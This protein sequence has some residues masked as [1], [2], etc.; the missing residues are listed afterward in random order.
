MHRAFQ[1]TVLIVVA[2]TA[3]IIY[4]SIF[5]TTAAHA[6]AGGAGGQDQCVRGGCGSPYG[7]G[8]S[9]GNNPWGWYQYDAAGSGPEY[10][11][12]ASWSQIKNACSA[13][14]YVIGFTLT[15][16]D[17]SRAIWAVRY[18][19]NGKEEGFNLRN[20]PNANERAAPAYSGNSGAPWVN[21]DDAHARYNLLPVPERDGTNWIGEPAPGFAH[22]ASWFCYDERSQWDSV[23][24]T[25]LTVNGG[26]SPTA[27]VGDNLRWTHQLSHTGATG[28]GGDVVSKTVLSGGFGLGFP[29]QANI[30]NRILNVGDVRRPT[31]YAGYTVQP[32]DVGKVLCQQL[33][34]D[35]TNSVGG[36]NG[37]SANACVSIYHSY[38]L[39]PSV[40][41]D[42]AEVLPGATI[43]V[44]TTVDNSGPSRSKLSDWRVSYIRVT[45]GNAIPSSGG[46]STD[47]PC[48]F[49][50]GAGRTC[51]EAGR[52]NQIFETGSTAPFTGSDAVGDVPVGTQ[53]CYV[54]SVQ[55]A[56][57]NDTRWAH[58]AARCAVVSK[59][60]LVQVLGN[61]LLVG[62]GAATPSSVMTSVKNVDGTRYGS[63]S[64]YGLSVSGSVSGMGS[65]AGYARGTTLA[66]CGVSLLTL[67]NYTGSTC[68]LGG[69]GNSK[70]RP[71]VESRF[72]VQGAPQ[73]SGS[74]SVNAL[75]TATTYT[76]N[77]AN[78]PITLTASGPVAGKWVVIN[79]PNADVRIDTNITYAAGPFTRTADI[80]Q[81]IIIA[82]NI[83]IAD[84]VT[85]VDAWLIARGTGTNGFI[86]TCD[87]AGEEPGNLN[88]RVCNQVLTVNGPVMA[89]RL[90]LYRT[91]GSGSGAASGDPA[92]V[93]NYR[94]DAY[95]W[96]SA[97]FSGQGKARTV[98]TTELPPRF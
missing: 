86:K 14:K 74:Q 67:T 32:D 51:T 43:G 5:Q 6:A 40:T 56:G 4:Q 91:A 58:S 63:W 15:N 3:A 26:V 10:V 28:S 49:F 97:Q 12:S 47:D 84:T 46:L 82:R 62:R 71:A 27:T 34:W 66:D 80:P 7:S 24:T 17:G 39:T 76:S 92:E 11:N 75:Q 60:P 42:Q 22:H 45:P 19:K 70:V 85:Q 64:E 36:R 16:R 21:W 44:R 41:I 25:S 78:A 8:G 30:E 29:T 53:L 50:Q 1:T 72:P 13:Y 2:L 83:T 20:T 52:G 38:S 69:Y 90:L 31:D 37:A 65:A 77:A 18:I 54:I 81:V 61:D 59:K 48:R 89:N 95:L 88:D 79:A 73:I 98:L 9:Y 94:P 57:A 93:F 33:Q 96:G 23:G 55:P 68:K 35:P 87:A